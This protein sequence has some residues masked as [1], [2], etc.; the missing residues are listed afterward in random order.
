[1]SNHWEERNWVVISNFL[2]RYRYV[3]MVWFLIVYV[4][5][6]NNA[7]I[8]NY[9]CQLQMWSCGCWISTIQW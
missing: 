1:L 3:K 9:L 8:N 7:H 2:Q 4:L 6:V 5:I